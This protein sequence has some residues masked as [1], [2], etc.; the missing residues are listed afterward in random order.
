MSYQHSGF[1]FILFL[2][3]LQF[4]CAS[5]DPIQLP[6]KCLEQKDCLAKQVCHQG[7]CRSVQE[8][9]SFAPDEAGNEGQQE[10]TN[11]FKDGGQSNDRQGIEAPLEHHNEKNLCSKSEVCDGKDNDCN[12]QVDE[13]LNTPCFSEQKGCTRKKGGS[14]HCLGRCRAGIK[15]CVN[16]KWSY[17]IGGVRPSPT[18]R[19]INQIDDDC[20][21]LVD[22]DCKGC[23]PENIS[24]NYAKI[25]H[26]TS[27]S[28]SALGILFS[29]DGKLLIT[30]RKTLKVWR[31]KDGTL[32]HTIPVYDPGR[33]LFHPDGKHLLIREGNK[34]FSLW[35]ISTGKK[36]RAYPI[37]IDISQFQANERAP[38]A[39]SFHPETRELL[40]MRI[41]V[42]RRAQF[43]I[44]ELRTGKTLATMRKKDLSKFR[45]GHFVSFSFSPD[46]KHVLTLY[47]RGL[48]SIHHVNTTIWNISTRKEIGHIRGNFL[49]FGPD[50]Q[51]IASIHVFTSASIDKVIFLDK[52]QLQTKKTISINT[53]FEPLFRSLHSISLAPTEQVIAA[54]G[55]SHHS[56]EKAVFLYSFKTQK[57]IRKLQQNQDVD[58]LAFDPSGRV[59]AI[60]YPDNTIKLWTCKSN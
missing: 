25:T 22:E 23:S 1:C 60:A 7:R 15:R 37:K 56:Q 18:E 38:Y 4:H 34:T 54:G 51:N 17:C 20:D 40:L 55:R 59:L 2:L 42:G 14:Y 45:D 9:G 13:Q 30:I 27:K 52:W 48:H 53:G 19:C 50:G 39:L 33:T 44:I 24:Y 43:E 29:P 21:G 57:L 35:E 5:P 12:G 6:A 31:V 8:K 3:L 47:R 11:D 32:S 10:Q 58:M 46:G 36:A 41:S 16:G 26:S 28:E 49:S